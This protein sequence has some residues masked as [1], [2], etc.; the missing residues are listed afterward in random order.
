[1]IAPLAGDVAFVPGLS[2][3][4]VVGHAVARV[5]DWLIPASLENQRSSIS[6]PR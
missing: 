5:I 2:F 6:I 4:Y 1:M 3:G